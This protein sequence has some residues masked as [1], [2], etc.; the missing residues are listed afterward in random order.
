MMAAPAR[1]GLSAALLETVS[2]LAPFP[3]RM[4]T[5]WRVAA[6]CALVAGIAMMFNIPESAISCYLVIFLMKADG[7]ENMV[8]AIAATLAITLL[9]A[10]MIPIIQWT[11]ESASLRIVIM[12]AVSFA[13]IF[14]GAASKLGEGGSIVALIIA[15]ILTLVNE[16]P[17]NGVISMALRYAWEMA[18]LPMLVIAVFNLY[19]G[20]WSVSLLRQELRDR[21]LLAR[22]ALLNGPAPL[23]AE[24][25]AAGNDDESKRAMLVRIL[26]QTSQKNAARI[27]ADIPASYQLLFAVS[28]L[29]EAVSVESRHSYASE[30]DAMVDALDRGAPLPPPPLAEDKLPCA[31][32]RAI[33]QALN[34]LAGQQE[35]RYRKGAGERFFAADAFT[36]PAYQRFALK[37]TLAAILCYMFYAAINW[38]GIH[39]AMVTCYV[40]S[41]GTAGDTLH[42]LVLRIAGCLIGAVIGVASI[43]LL[44]PQMETVGSLMV[45]VF[46]VALLAA[47]VAGGSEKLSY[48]GVQIGLAFTLTVLQG[49]GP[50]TDMDTARDRILGV[51]VGNLAVYLVSTLIWPAP[52]V[53]VIRQHLAQA[54]RKIAQIAACPAASR[55]EMINTAAEVELLLGEVRYCFY[56]LPFEPL[57][58]RPSE[59]LEKTFESLTDQLASLN[60]DVYFC[61]GV[62]DSSAVRLEALALRIEQAAFNEIGLFNTS[63]AAEGLTR[64]PGENQIGTRLAR[65]EAL[66]AGGPA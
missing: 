39:T 29:P 48:A 63:Q 57:Q 61:E 41:L 44:M 13:F 20:R 66:L 32:A 23:V 54:A 5:A 31:Q 4:A 42:K 37:T 15:F 21:L 22:Q 58:L 7:A 10:L 14:L 3:G 27:K 34:T 8:V 43:I 18:I 19:F 12:I 36:N 26:H 35:P 45:L 2:D 52:V 17:V 53:T 60:K 55:M 6:V 33:R 64:D 24:K 1:R 51:L 28:A 50:T 56:L 62:A 25:L 46:F 65:L 16:V 59:A 9:I 11:V 40:A 49:F 30:I 47:W 38:Q